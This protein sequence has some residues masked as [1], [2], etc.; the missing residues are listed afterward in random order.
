MRRPSVLLK[1]CNL[2]Q[3]LKGS[4]FLI[5]DILGKISIWCCLTPQTWVAAGRPARSRRFSGTRS[6]TDRA[7][8]WLG[9]LGRGAGSRVIHMQYRRPRCLTPI[10]PRNPTGA[11]ANWWNE[12]EGLIKGSWLK[13]IDVLHLLCHSSIGLLGRDCRGHSV[14]PNKLNK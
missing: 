9:V 13:C 1:E 8:E 2:F 10:P 7:E 5:I 3:T 11:G 12:Q 14:L 4:V 6:P